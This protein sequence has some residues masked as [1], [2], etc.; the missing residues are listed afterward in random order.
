MSRGRADG[1]P[2]KRLVTSVL[3]LVIICG[4]LYLYSKKNGSSGLEYGSKIRKFGST[5][6]GADEDVDESPPK[7]GED[8][9]DGVILKSIP[10]CDDRHSELIPCLDRNLIYE[11]R[12]KLDLSVMEHYERH[13]PVP[14]RRYNCLI[15][16]PPGY[17]I[18][19]KWPKSRD[20]VWKA[21]IP[22]THLATEKSDQKWMVVKGE[23]IGFPGGGTHFH[24]GADKYIASM[25]NMLNFPNNI[26]NNGGSLRTVL[27]VGCGVASFGGYLLSSDIIAMS[28]A[29]N[30]VHQNQIQFA[31]ERGIPAYLGVLGTKRLP[32]PSRS[33]ELAHCSR[34][35]IDWLQRDGILL[36]EL[37][38]VLRP[39]GY[40]AYSSPEAYAQDEEDL[41]IWKA[42]SALVERMCWK[43][44]SKRNQTVIWVKPLTN[45]CYMERP[46]GTQPPLCRSDDDPD[47][48]YNVKMEACITPY[49]EQNHRARGSG[50]A[51][52]PARLTTPPP[53]LG[54]FGYSSD[55]F[56]KDMEVW[57]QRVENYWNHLSPK[58]SSDTIRNVMDMKAN[59]GS[60]A[61][62]LKN[63]DVWVMDVV[64]EDGPKTIKIIYDRGLIGSVHNW[65]EAYSTYPRTYDL[66]HAWTVFSDIE[67]KEC[68]GVDLLIEMDRILRPKGFIIVR[69]KR[70]VVEFINKYMKA[71][72]W[73]AVATADAEGG[74]ELDDDVVFIIQKK[75]WRTSESFRNVE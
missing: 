28:L 66:L 70:K 2:K 34:C 22:H 12:L 11:T 49:S 45:D 52:W 15:P 50:L 69:D 5:Y 19:I 72:H 67:R 51:P 65:C 40:F 23:K 13:C 74:S 60:F 47:A 57:Q 21:N 1:I 73:E 48:V 36:L 38:R 18:P 71:L 20:E 64:H 46:P 3:V 7:L 42:M 14:E 6:L 37:D 39:G 41:K 75:I 24:Y 32:Y 27:D 31:L 43:I 29:P 53:R 30:D 4:L 68:S 8:E 26:L 16:P 55:I 44:A 56:E 17:K 61:G 63:K 54:D 9:E 25:A 10:V 35:R 62:A 33:F 59:L 58:I